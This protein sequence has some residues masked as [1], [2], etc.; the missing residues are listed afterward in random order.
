MLMEEPR[1]IMSRTETKEPSF[2]N[3][4][5]LKEEPNRETLRKENDELIPVKS[6]TDIDDPS[7]PMP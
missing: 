7:V 6:S 5:R 3:P 1:C 2:A 4:Y